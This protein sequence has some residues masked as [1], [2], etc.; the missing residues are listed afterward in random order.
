MAWVAAG[1]N[2]HIAQSVSDFL[3]FLE[4][5]VDFMT[6]KVVFESSSYLRKKGGAIPEKGQGA[7]VVVFPRADGHT[8]PSVLGIAQFSTVLG[9]ANRPNIRNL[10]A[11]ERHIT[12]QISQGQF[13]QNSP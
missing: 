11:T 3:E 8:K 2:E 5:Q 10:E 13:W 4:V 7:R 12:G 1:Q 9:T 6:Y